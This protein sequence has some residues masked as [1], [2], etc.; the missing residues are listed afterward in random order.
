[1]AFKYLWTAGIF[2]SR[3]EGSSVSVSMSG[4]ANGGDRNEEM[5]GDVLKTLESASGQI[6]KIATNQK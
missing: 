5:Y 6:F 4:N 2:K 1:M 3:A